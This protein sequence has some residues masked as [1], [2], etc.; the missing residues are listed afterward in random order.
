MK[1]NNNPTVSKRDRNRKVHLEF[2]H[3]S[4]QA[5]FVAG[6][7]NDWHPQVTE[8]IRLKPGLWAK[9]LALPPGIYEYRF[10]VDGVWIT[11]PKV[12]ESVPNP[13]GSHNSVLRA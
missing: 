12:A 6:S 8:M 13:F 4:A 9:E 7:F 11:D 3:S 5:V 1:K 2:E 10:V